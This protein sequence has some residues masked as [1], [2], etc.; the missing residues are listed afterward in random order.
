MHRSRNGASFKRRSGNR[1][2]EEC[3]THLVQLAVTERWAGRFCDELNARL[4]PQGTASWRAK[5]EEHLSAAW[6]YEVFMVNDRSIT[7]GKIV[8]L[9]FCLFLSVFAGAF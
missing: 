5:A 6:Q 8:T 3:E 1:C 4:K 2:A 7:I 9:I